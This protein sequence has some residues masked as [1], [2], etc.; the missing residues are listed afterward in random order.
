MSDEQ[1]DNPANPSE[2]SPYQV[3]KDLA[4]EERRFLHDLANPLAIAAGIVD[5]ILH[6]EFEPQTLDPD[7]KNRLEKAFNA[8]EKMKTLMRIR[9]SEL[10]AVGSEAEIQEAEKKKP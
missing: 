2:K 10:I 3:I 9:R 7:Q 8:M 6:D 5:I 4:L 1:N